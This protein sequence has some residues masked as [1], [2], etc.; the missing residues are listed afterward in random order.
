MI[1]IDPEKAL[2]FLLDLFIRIFL[3]W[4]ASKVIEKIKN[5]MKMPPPP[6]VLP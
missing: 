4:I 2:T 1:D 5:S 6:R 3:G